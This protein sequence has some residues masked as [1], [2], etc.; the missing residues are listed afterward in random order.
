MRI[1]LTRSPNH[2]PTPYTNR[3]LKLRRIPPLI[4]PKIKRTRPLRNQ[5]LPPKTPHALRTFLPAPIAPI[6][7]I[8]IMRFR[9]MESTNR[10][11][12]MIPQTAHIRIRER[13][14]G[15]LV[16]ADRTITA[17]GLGQGAGGAAEPAVGFW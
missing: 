10:I 3:L 15:S 6:S 14:V 2:L 11:P 7:P 12:H 4:P 8:L 16:I 5:I 17:L 13:L 9:E 1:R